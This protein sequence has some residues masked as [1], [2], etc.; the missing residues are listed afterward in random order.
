M[1]ERKGAQAR[2][3]HDARLPRHAR[4]GH[5]AALRH[6]RPVPD[7]SRAAG[8]RATCASRSPSASTATARS[9]TRA[10]RGGGAR[11]A[12]AAR[13]RRLRG[14]RG[15]L[16]ATP[17]AIPR[18]SGAVGRHRPRGLP[19]AVRSRCPA[20]WSP[21]SG[22]Y[23]R[24]V[25][26]CANAY[27]Q[28]LMDRYLDAARARARGARLRRR[29]APDA[30]GR[31]PRLAG[32]GARPSRSACS[33]A[34]RPAAASPPR[35]SASSPARR[36]VISFD[37]GGTTAKACMI[38]DGR[39]EIAPMMEAGARPP[40]HQ[41]LRPADQGAGD[42]HDRDRRR[43]RLDRGDRRGRPAQGRPAF[44]RL[45]SRPGLL[46]HGRQEADRHR[47]Q[48]GARLLR[49]GLLPRR[50]HEAR[51][52]G[53]AQRA[54]ATRRRAARPRRS[55]KRPGASTRSSS[56]AWPA[57]ARV[58]LVEKGKDP[59]R[60]AM[61]GFGGAGPAHAADVARVLG[62]A[63]GDHSAGLR[64]GLGARLPRGAAVLRAGALAAGRVLP[65]GFDADA[66]QRACSASSK[67]RAARSSPRPASRPRDIVVERSADMRLVGQMHDIAVPLPDGAHRRREP[68]RDP[69]GLRARP[70]PRATP[71]VYEGAR[72]R[73]S[74]SASAASARRRRL[75]LAGAA[76]GG[77]AAAKVKGT[78]RPGSTSGWRRGGGLRPLRAARRRHASP[79]RRSS[80]SAR[81]PP[82]S[83]PG[84]SRRGRRRPATCASP[85]ASP[86]AADAIV[87]AD[88]P[89][90]RGGRA[91]SRP[92]RSRSRS[93]GA[94]SSTSSRRCGS[95]SAAPPSRW[96]SPRRR[97][98][99]A[100]CSTPTAR[101]WRI[102]R[103]PCRCST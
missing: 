98:S 76:G 59:R 67:R 10:R 87:T 75:S 1:I 53:G 80:R 58:H 25:T 73:R 103:A 5:R 22:E 45:R 61:V 4:N 47:R 63:R 26:T 89:H 102:R 83:P 9:S 48:S 16:P 82:S 71:R 6:L 43:R 81:R 8:R 46:R 86:R 13:R 42:R 49:S 92:I 14:D 40:L 57:A 11:R 90:R 99:P 21:R 65:T 35:C 39:A 23:Q 38:E 88:M 15:L 7:V 84:D 74:T 96:S 31:R 72:S 12:R 62:V 27:V 93:C 95:R 101:R 34:A 69:R 100:N 29:A 19:R 70:T 18:T 44:G 3:D 32:D 36:D 2:P 77:D 41:G 37:M 30:F 54:V 91:A 66:R 78:P 60:Y 97:I 50:P 52:R 51:P 28:P 68:R 79:A 56:R 55:R 20:R 94:A 85:S 64:R 17:T 33:K 24:C